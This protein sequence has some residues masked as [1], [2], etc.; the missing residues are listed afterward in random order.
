MQWS[1]LINTGDV[2]LCD[3]S[4]ALVFLH[5]T[6]S[7]GSV[8]LVSRGTDFSDELLR[9]FFINDMGGF[10]GIGGRLPTTYALAQEAQKYALANNFTFTLSGHSLGIIYSYYYHYFFINIHL[11]G[12][13]AS[14]IAGIV[15]VYTFNAPELYHSPNYGV[16]EAR[17]LNSDNAHHWR[18]FNDGVSVLGGKP[19]QERGHSVTLPFDG[20]TIDAH[21]W[22]ML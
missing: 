4:Y 18:L 5:Q 16:S 20:N 14:A 9:D 3:Y 21:V 1:L 12:S 8:V 19:F 7:L 13:I 17:F 22:L 2:Q 10:L 11:G 15:G 6:Y